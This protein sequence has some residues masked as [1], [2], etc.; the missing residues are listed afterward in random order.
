MSTGAAVAAQD[1][2]ALA[3]R[4]VRGSVIYGVTNFGLKA[5][6]FLLL[7]V[8]ARYL[9]PADFGVISL[10]EIVAAVVAGLCSLGLDG[11]LRRMYFHY[12]DQPSTLAR[13]VCTVLRF[14]AVVTFAL[15]GAALVLGPGLLSRIAPQF[16]VPFYPYIAIAI[17][18]AAASQLVDYRFGLY[19][20][21][22]RP[23]AYSA[24]SATSFALTTVAA[25]IFVVALRWGA[26]GMLAGK[27][28]GAVL[29]LCVAIAL[30]WRWLR[31]GW[32][33]K[34]IRE[35]LPL[36]LPLL[37]HLLLALGLVAA[38]RFILQH[39]RPLSEVGLYSLAYT[40]G[41]IMFLA[42]SSLS[43]AWSP[44][45]YDVARSGEDGRRIIGRM[46]LGV[47]MLLVVIASFGSLIAQDFV[48]VFLDPRYH[49]AGRVVP[50]I[51]GAYLLHAFFS[52]FQASAL[53]ARKTQFIWFV[54][55]T[56][57][58]ANIG[59]NLALI[60]RWGM[61]GAAWA[62]LAAYAIEALLMFA[63]AQRV[64][65]FSAAPGFGSPCL[66]VRWRDCS[67]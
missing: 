67:A 61:Y 50:W 26:L 56:A 1:A 16:E 17:V 66:P 22:Q 60:P 6:N 33:G 46:F 55:L 63:F 4:L 5:A 10:S 64:F 38:D 36:A 48:D 43:Q 2:S 45:F 19:Q 15:T 39:Y 12:V 53:Q 59:L 58:S 34:Y 35:V 20:S 51:I 11:A 65:R 40:F 49:P 41:M 37:P 7:T 47:T 62:T 32:E 28:A 21:E 44:L 29:S 27:C 9:A 14:G 23:R 3:G 31:A 13:Y 52:L 24:F 42:T 54:S 57:F 18:T 25:L 30:S 8:Y